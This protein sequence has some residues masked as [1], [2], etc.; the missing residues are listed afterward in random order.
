MGYLGDGCYL[1]GIGDDRP[2][3]GGSW[4]IRPREA[5]SLSNSANY[6]RQTRLISRRT[7][8]GL[9]CSAHHKL[10][11]LGGPSPCY[12]M[13]PEPLRRPTRTE[14]NHR[15]VPLCRFHAGHHRATSRPETLRNLSSDIA[16]TSDSDLRRD[17]SGRKCIRFPHPSRPRSIALLLSARPRAAAA[18]ASL[19]PPLER[20]PFLPRS[21]PLFSPSP[22]DRIAIVKYLKRD[23]DPALPSESVLQYRAWN[24]CGRVS[25]GPATKSRNFNLIG[26]DLNRDSSDIETLMGGPTTPAMLSAGGEE[27][28]STFSNFLWGGRVCLTCRRDN[29]RK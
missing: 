6:G 17:V 28:L 10:L 27:I 9:S 24:C 11:Q 1:R 2:L 15:A 21:S 20:H 18:A 12:T 25:N 23:F 3:R 26:L 5:S 8:I 29:K 7:C 14:S 4:L 19:A 22:V 13:G 16:K